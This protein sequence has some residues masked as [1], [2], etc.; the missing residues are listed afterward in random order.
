MIDFRYHIVS[1]VA[2]FLALAVGLVLGTTQLDPILTKNLKD[3][4]HQLTADKQ[5]LRDQLSPADQS[6]SHDSAFIA[7]V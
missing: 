1:I 6:L 4:V 7:A 3:S 2:I 5:S